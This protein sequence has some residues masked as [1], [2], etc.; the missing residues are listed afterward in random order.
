MQLS[1]AEFKTNCLNLIDRI[2]ETQEEVS[3]T[4]HGKIIAKLVTIKNKTS[5]KLFG[6]LKGRIQENEDI[7][8]DL[9]LN[10]NEDLKTD[11]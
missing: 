9:D 1:A 2:Q 6:H 11:P 8:P 5:A 7:V 10:W 3:I 4:K